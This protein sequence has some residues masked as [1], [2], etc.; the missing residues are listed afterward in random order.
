MS[1]CIFN[2][3]K[4]FSDNSAQE[5]RKKFD[6]G[7]PKG[8]SCSQIDTEIA[9]IENEKNSINGKIASGQKEK[10]VRGALQV[11]E[12]RLRDAKNRKSS[13]KCDE[14]KAKLEQQREEQK[15]LT[16]LEQTTKSA[17]Q[18]DPLEEALEAAKPK[19]LDT[20]MY[21][22]LG[23]GGIFLIGAIVLLIKK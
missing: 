17:L 12:E 7:I 5:M 20:T 11:L 19:G 21:I 4:V 18:K 16:L 8:A 14:L 3:A 22:A 2:C 1:R 13:Q 6:A 15:N 9:R 23:V 10:Y